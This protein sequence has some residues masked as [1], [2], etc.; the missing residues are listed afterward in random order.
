MAYMSQGGQAFFAERRP[1]PP[2]AVARIGLEKV[3]VV[4]V[5][6]TPCPNGQHFPRKG[7]KNVCCFSSVCEHYNKVDCFCT[8]GINPEDI[9]VL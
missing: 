9:A 7:P 4:G 1:A 2:P 5:T 3:K 6:K 8:L